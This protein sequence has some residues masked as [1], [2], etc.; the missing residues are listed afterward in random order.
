MFKFKSWKMWLQKFRKT[1]VNFFDGVVLLMD[2]Q[3]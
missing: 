1:Q 2:L 3:A